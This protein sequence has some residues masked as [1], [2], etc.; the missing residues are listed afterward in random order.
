MLTIIDR[1]GMWVG[2]LLTITEKGGGGIQTPPPPPPQFFKN[3]GKKPGGGGGEGSPPPPRECEKYYEGL[4]RIF[5]TNLR[6]GPTLPL[7]M[8]KIG[9]K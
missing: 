9:K 5:C 1:G 6:R 2:Q 8:C 7:R 4:V 3:F